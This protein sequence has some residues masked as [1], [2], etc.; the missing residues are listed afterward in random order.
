ME[1]YKLTVHEAADLIKRKELP[2]E[3]TQ[4]VLN[5]IEQVEQDVK[6][7][8]LTDSSALEEAQNTDAL[9]NQDENI[10]DIAGIPFGLED[11]I[12][13]AGI[14]TTCASKMLENFVP[15]Y[16]A[17]VSGKLRESK[18]I[19]LGKLNMDEFSLGV[20]TETS[21]FHKSRNPWDINRDIG[22]FC[23]ALLHRLLMRCFIRWLPIQVVH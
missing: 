5:R 19:L 23:G 13:T 10:S 2:F 7:I 15:Q 18:G 21:Y 22:S 12:C 3:L 11:N 8:T 1:A 17:A 16:E 20:A 6:L 9:I 14:K 4:A